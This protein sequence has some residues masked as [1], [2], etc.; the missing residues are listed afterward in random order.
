VGAFR[1]AAG[2]G[3]CIPDA[4]SDA[5]RAALTGSESTRDLV[6]RYGRARHLGEK[7][8]GHQD[9]GATSIALLFQGFHDAL[10]ESKGETGN[11]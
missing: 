7:V 3:K 5:A 8:R 1:A 9:P 4:L 10:A 11:A 6:A 2:G